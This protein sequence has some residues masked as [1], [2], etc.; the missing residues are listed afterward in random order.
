MVEDIITKYNSDGVWTSGR[1]C[2]FHGCDVSKQGC[3]RGHS[4]L[5]KFSC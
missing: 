4:L 1:L 2:N 5:Q 3:E